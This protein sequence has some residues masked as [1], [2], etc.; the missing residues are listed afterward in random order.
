MAGVGSFLG[1]ENLSWAL[2]R[3]QR[4]RP[5]GPSIEG[6]NGVQANWAIGSRSFLWDTG[7]KTWLSWGGVQGGQ[8]GVGGLQL[9]KTKLESERQNFVQ[10]PMWG[11]VRLQ[12]A[13]MGEETDEETLSSVRGLF[14]HSRFF[15][16]SSSFQCPS[17]SL[18]L[19]ICSVDQLHCTCF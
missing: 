8:E 6:P 5:S 16:Y 4:V 17:Y 18:S 14:A 9:E 1:E 7:G 13:T 19:R 10:P 15:S 11:R 12:A 3:R 2:N